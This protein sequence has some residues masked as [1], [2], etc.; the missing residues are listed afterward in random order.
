MDQAIHNHINPTKSITNKQQDR[1]LYYLL[2]S[3]YFNQNLYGPLQR[4]DITNNSIIKSILDLDS[5]YKFYKWIKFNGIRYLIG[6]MI[7][8]ENL[9]VPKFG[10]ILHLIVKSTN[11]IFYLDKFE[12]IGYVS[13]FRSYHLNFLNNST[14]FAIH[15]KDLLNIYP[16]DLYNLSGKS[17]VCLKLKNLLTF[18][19]SRCLNSSI[20]NLFDYSKFRLNL[21]SKNQK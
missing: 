17:Y 4:V 10:Q 20:N 8:Y 6:D 21:I 5:S 19:R 14:N 18:L 7:C 3:N 15:L 1:Q 2:S 16:I 12:T 13:Y 9:T 11:L